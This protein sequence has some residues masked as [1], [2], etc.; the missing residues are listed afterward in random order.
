MPRGKMATVQMSKTKFLF[1]FLSLFLAVTDV[2]AQQRVENLTEDTTPLTSEFN[3]LRLE[4]VA[5]IATDE[6]A[7]ARETIIIWR[8][9]NGERSRELNR[10]RLYNVQ[11]FLSRYKTI[12]AENIV[13][14]E[15]EKVRGF[16][17]VEI[18]VGGKLVTT[19]TVPKNEDLIID[20]CEGDT[21][22]YPSKDLLQRSNRK[23]KQ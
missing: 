17:R 20:C 21:D 12:G 14:A 22:F 18:Y 7:E 10:R 13:V 5:R 9:G 3:I 1:L 4:D 8:L 11:T 6:A 15:A 2:F 23:R 16:G 19:L